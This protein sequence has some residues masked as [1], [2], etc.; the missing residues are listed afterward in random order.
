MKA[1]GEPSERSQVNARFRG[2][3]RRR[4][5]TFLR[6]ASSSA[7]GMAAS[8]A[9]GSTMRIPHSSKVSRTAAILSARLGLDHRAPS[10]CKSRSKGEQGGARTGRG[11]AWQGREG[12]R[13]RRDGAGRGEGGAR[14]DGARERRDG[15]S[16]KTGRGEGGARRDGAGVGRTQQQQRRW[17]PAELSMHRCCRRHR[18][19]RPG[20]RALCESEGPDRS[21]RLVNA[22]WRHPVGARLVCRTLA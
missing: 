22:G 4:T 15:V 11:G 20:R 21:E 8:V 12:A 5:R 9:A 18:S 3:L 17:G 2:R 1:R 13:E 7:A 10:S 6:Q 16:W 14:R 19:H